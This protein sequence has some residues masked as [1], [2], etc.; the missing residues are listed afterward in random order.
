MLMISVTTI[1]LQGQTEKVKAMF[2]YNF[3]KYVQWPAASQT[4]T[5]LINVYGNS[6]IFDE[7]VKISEMKSAGAQPIVVKRVATPS[8]IANPH[9]IYVSANRQADIDQIIK[10][11]SSKPTLIITESKGMIEKGAAINFILVDNKQRFEIKRDNI[12][13]KGLKISSELEKFAIIR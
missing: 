6:P 10:Q 1:T 4:G 2:V 13:G 9:I 3:T 5:F 8:E 7:L 11:V 12:T